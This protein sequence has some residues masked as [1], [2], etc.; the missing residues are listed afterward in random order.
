MRSAMTYDDIEELYSQSGGEELLAAAREPHPD[1]EMTTAQLL[2]SAGK[3]FQQAEEHG[4]ALAAFRA[5]VATGEQTEPDARCYLVGGLLKAGLREEAAELSREVRRSRLQ[6]ADSYQFIGE[7][8]E[9]VDEPDVAIRWFTAGLL[10][11]ERTG[12]TGAVHLLSVARPRVRESMGFPP[13][14]YDE[15]AGSI[16]D[17]LKQRLA[18]QTSRVGQEARSSLR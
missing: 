9:L 11:A 3:V 6:D 7:S 17:R 18:G 10:Q 14:E 1:D 12:A 16:V 8:W 4:R 5:A 13:D 15:M 2:V